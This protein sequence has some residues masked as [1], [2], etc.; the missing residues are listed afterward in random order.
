MGTVVTFY[1]Y[2]GG[3]GRTMA[4]ANVAVLLAKWGYRTLMVDWDLEAPGLEFYFR[5]YLDWEDVARQRGIVE[6]LCYGYDNKAQAIEQSTWQDLLCEIPLPGSAVPLSLLTAGDRSDGYFDKV[7]NL[8]LQTFYDDRDGGLFIESL[9]NEWKTAYDFVLVDSRTGIT[10][11]GGVCTVQLP[12]TLVLLF[13]A[14]EQSLIGAVDVAGRAHQARQE[15]PFDRNTLL[16]VPV[17]SRFDLT[18]EFGVSKEWLKRFVSETAALYANWLRKDVDREAFLLVTKIP[19]MAYF[20]FGEKLP[21]IEQGTTDPTGLGYA[22]ETLAALI[23]NGLGHAEQV[24]ENRGEFVRL[25]SGREVET[26]PE[27]PAKRLDSSTPSVPKRAY[28]AQKLVGKAGLPPQLYRRCFDALL[29]CQE[30]SSHEALQALFV[31]SELMPFG[32]VLP[33]A[34]TMSDRVAQ[35]IAYLVAIRLSDGRPVLPIFLATLRNRLRPGDA[36][37]DQLAALVQDIEQELSNIEFI[38]ETVD[39]PFVIVAM[40]QDEASALLGGTVFDSPEVAPSERLRFEQLEKA[41][42]EHITEEFLSRY[43]ERREDWIPFAGSPSTIFEIVSEVIDRTNE[44]AL[45]R[46]LQ[47]LRPVFL[48]GSFFAVDQTERVETWKQLGTSGCVLVADPISLFH[49]ELC[50]A[51]GRS[52]LDWGNLTAVAVLSPPNGH[53]EEANQLIEELIGR[54]MPRMFERFSVSFDRLVEISIRDLRAFQRWLFSTLPEV[55]QMLLKQRFTPTSRRLFREKVGS[56]KGID[57]L[58]FGDRSDQ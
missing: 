52:G 1:S 24:L 4:L 13:T 56:P 22:Y 34:E 25:A 38:G 7:R 58:I 11:I 47:V 3:V 30:F 17:P 2:K 28:R 16:S 19:Y 33:R 54:Q 9:R 55:A 31:V 8:N 26:R 48:S 42:G 53:S 35:L 49:P 36:L 14:N 37:R 57:R 15:L 46:S 10:D 45:E 41:P 23:A 12:D 27:Q 6:L 39:I 40:T 51:V 32:D 18:E 20:S 5:E 50:H 44:T 21:V 43:G 29:Q